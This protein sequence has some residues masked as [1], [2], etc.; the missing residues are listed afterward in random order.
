KDF[1]R[2]KADS[3]SGQ[4]YHWNNNAETF[5]LIGE[6]MGRAMLELISGKQASAARAK[7]TWSK[8]EVI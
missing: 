2:D 8:K 7:Y 6:G 3:P 1:W 4:A 5:Y